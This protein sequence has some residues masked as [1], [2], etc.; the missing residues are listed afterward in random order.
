MLSSHLENTFCLIRHL[1]HRAIQ[2]FI[3]VFEDAGFHCHYRIAFSDLTMAALHYSM[4]QIPKEW[5]IEVQNTVHEPVG[6][7]LS[8]GGEE[9]PSAKESQQ[10]ILSMSVKFLGLM[11]REALRTYQKFS[12]LEKMTWKH[13]NTYYLPSIILA[14]STPQSIQKY[15]DLTVFSKLRSGRG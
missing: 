13:K 7:I 3:Q 5:L 1:A 8:K 10:K 9:F 12:F 2:L 6:E 15:I 11:R 14:L 4:L